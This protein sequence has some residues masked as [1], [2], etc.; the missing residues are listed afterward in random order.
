[1][2][3]TFIILNTISWFLLAVTWTRSNNSNLLCKIVLTILAIWSGLILFNHLGWIYQ[4]PI[5]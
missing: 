4:G 3:T 5:S 1:M 2:F